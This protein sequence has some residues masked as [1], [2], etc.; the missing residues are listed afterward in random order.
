[1]AKNKLNLKKILCAILFMAM[2]GLLIGAYFIPVL[3]NDLFSYNCADIIANGSSNGSYTAIAVM[4]LISMILGV[5][6]IL[7]ALVNL[8]A[9][10]KNLDL[11]MVC[12]SVLIAILGV[13]ALII[14]ITQ[15][16]KSMGITTV[17]GF[18]TFAIIIAG[19][20]ALLIALFAKSK[21]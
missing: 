21:L 13:V 17:L 18:G 4:G 19:V 20:V 6:L 3:S 9:K 5:L 1:M 16:G 14:A 15:T 12:V 7:G 11:V 8:F 2:G 10:V